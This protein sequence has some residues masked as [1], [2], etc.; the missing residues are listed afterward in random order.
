MKNKIIVCENVVKI[1]I[2]AQFINLTL[3]FTIYVFS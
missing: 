2:T 3:P 1:Q